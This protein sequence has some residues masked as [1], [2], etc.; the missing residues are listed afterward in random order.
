MSPKP[1]VHWAAIGESTFVAGMRFMAGLHRLFGRVPFLLVLYPVVFYYWA[2]RGV[3]R[4]ASRQYLER[5]QAAHN[6]LGHPPTWRD[7][8]R[9]FL[10]FADTLLDKTLALSGRYSFAGLRYEGREAVVELIER[11]Q[12]ALFVTGHV[13]CLEMCQVAAD[14][15]SRI[16]LSVLVHTAHAEQFNRMLHRLDP[17][18]GVQLIQV[19]EVGPATAVLLA[20]RVARGEFIAIAGDRIPL[21]A[22]NVTRASFLGHDAAFPIGPYVMASLLKCPMFL[23]TCVREGRGHVVR[24]ECLAEQVVLP[25][26]TR[27]AALAHFAALYAAR[28]EGVLASAPFEWFNFFP[29]WDQHLAAARPDSRTHEQPLA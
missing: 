29:F 13:G 12:G 11:A 28:L 10:A 17:N 7:G 20:E 21:D 5:V 16:K 8:V 3:A 24:F 25:R 27:S 4:R 15:R 26:K 19:S 9:H 2:S 22:N 18:H 14:R 1:P 6:S 23:M